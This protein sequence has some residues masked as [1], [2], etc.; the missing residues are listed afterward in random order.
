VRFRQLPCSL[1]VSIQC[2]GNEELLN[3]F[4]GD[5][6]PMVAHTWRSAVWRMPAPSYGIPRLPPW[7]AIHVTNTNLFGLGVTVAE[8]TMFSEAIMAREIDALTKTLAK[9]PELRVLVGHHP[10]FTPGKRTLRYNGDGELLYM[11]HL[12]RAI[13]ETGVHFYFSGHEHHQS[14]MT[15]LGCEHIT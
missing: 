3:V 8:V 4:A 11:R 10:I 2:I 1:S 14:H 15:G 9:A 5:A 7:I 6:T 13:E 12:R